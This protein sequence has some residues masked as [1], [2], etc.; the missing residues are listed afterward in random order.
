MRRKY[1]AAFCAEALRRTELLNPGYHS[2]LEYQF[3]I[4]L[5]LATN[6]SREGAKQ[7]NS[8]P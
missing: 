3:Q 1:D 8:H 4:V 2:R 5:P 6:L 7:G